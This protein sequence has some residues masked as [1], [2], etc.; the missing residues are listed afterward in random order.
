MLS[1]ASPKQE[2]PSRV[3]NKLGVAPLVR[4]ENWYAKW[5]KKADVLKVYP[6][7]YSVCWDTNDWTIQSGEGRDHVIGKGSSVM[8]AWASVK[9]NK[10]TKDEP[11]RKAGA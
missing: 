5:Q 2:L 4:S 3:I 7:A 10:E 11:S 8:K 6:N 1:S 9:L